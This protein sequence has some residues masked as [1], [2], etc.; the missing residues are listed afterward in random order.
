MIDFAHHC[1]YNACKKFSNTGTIFYLREGSTIIA[2]VVAVVFLLI[3][4]LIVICCVVRR[5]RPKPHKGKPLQLLVA[6][7]PFNI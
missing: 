6:N 4:V 2:A 7:P 3:V 5:G 1:S